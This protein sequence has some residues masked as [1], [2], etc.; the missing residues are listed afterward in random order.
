[1]K[2]AERRSH[3]RRIKARARRVMKLWGRPPDARR[4]GV[5]ASTHCRPCGGAMD[6]EPPKIRPMRERRFDGQDFTPLD[7]NG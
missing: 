3:E 5:N 4:L 2:R 1:M 6:Q 7:S